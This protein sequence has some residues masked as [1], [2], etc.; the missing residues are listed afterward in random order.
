M[1]H[2]QSFSAIMKE[3]AAS[4]DLYIASNGDNPEFHCI[5]LTH[6]SDCRKYPLFDGFDVLYYHREEKERIKQ[7]TGDLYHF[8]RRELKHQKTKLPRL[9][10]EYDQAL[11]CDKWK[12]WGDLLYTW[13][14]SDTKGKKQIQ[15]QD[16]ESDDVITVPL[17]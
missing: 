13:N 16:Y 2:G 5:A 7:I 10:N 11:D 1:A 9:L 14:I 12:K 4:N 3:V 6:L 17:L 8:V 15:L